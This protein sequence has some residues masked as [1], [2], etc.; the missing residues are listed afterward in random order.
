MA[1]STDL[2]LVSGMGKLSQ[3]LKDLPLAVRERVLLAA[4]DA[5]IQPIKTWAKRFAKRSERTG[6]LR[7][8]IIAKTK[9]AE[10]HYS[11]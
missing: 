2:K 1:N 7:N 8:S 3:L 11:E 6:A 4:T 9:S 10:G 5:A